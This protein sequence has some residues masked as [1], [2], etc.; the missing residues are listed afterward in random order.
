MRVLVCI[1]RVPDSSGQV[2][3]T[4]DSQAI[5]GRFAG[6][7]VSDHENCAVE[8]AVQLSDDVTV[9]TLG[10]PEA[11]EQL[12]TALGVGATA[13]VHIEAEP[14]NFGPTDI[15]KEIAAVVRE[16]EADGR[17]YDLILLG[18]DA[19]DSGD[20]QV[21]I[22]LAYELGRPVVTGI[23]TVSAVEG[24]V[25]AVGDGPDGGTETYELALPA[26]VAIL[27]GGVGPRYPTI[28][29]RMA[30]KKIAIE[31]RLPSATP[32][33]ASR[34]QLTL[35]PPVPSN[36]QILGNGP[37]AAAEVVDLFGRLGVLTK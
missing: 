28:K 24:A 5:D 12:R 6:F 25:T 11:V 27:E 21:P 13:A 19:A 17:G 14:K 22:R 9:I 30:A 16:H 26:V 23:K 32:V 33:G 34:V 10:A 35:P 31:T 1:K 18:N 15:A 8:T 2:V 29:G 36:V 7:T 3:L 4:E 20:F 37:E